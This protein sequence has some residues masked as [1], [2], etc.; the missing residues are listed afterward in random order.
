MKWMTKD[1]DMFLKEKDYVDTALIP[2]IPFNFKENT[3]SAAAMAEYT[4]SLT[5]EMERQFKGRLML[6]SPFTYLQSTDIQDY[7]SE[8]VKWT[9]H[10]REQGFK[11]VFLMT[12]D[13]EWRKVE[14]ELQSTLLWLPALPLENLDEEYKRQIVQEQVK[15]LIPLFIEK[16]QV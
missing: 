4:S 12:S 8:V 14:E 11:H 13:S 6:L 16:W 2:M 15:Q 10:L 9:G 7:K 3:K 5:G 1:V